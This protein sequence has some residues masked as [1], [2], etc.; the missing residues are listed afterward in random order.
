MLDVLQGFVHELR[1]AGLPVSMTENLDAMRAIEYVP[2]RRPH[3]VQ[4]RARRDAREERR[5]LPGVRHGLRGVLLDVLARRRRRRRA[6][7]EPRVAGQLRGAAR[8]HGP[9]RR[10]EPGVERGARADAPRRADADG[11][12]RDAHARGRGGRALRGDGAGPARRRRVLPLPHA[13]AARRRRSRLQDDGEGAR[14]SADRRGRVRRAARPGRLRGPA[15]GPEGDDRSGDPQ[16]ARR[17]SRGRGDGA[18]A[19]QAVARRRR[20]HARVSR[21][22]AD[23]AEGDLS[24]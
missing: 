1:T 3:R 24:A 7:H 21:R 17:G 11:P 20:L 23:A 8:R 22:D 19:A 6:R 10:H 2:A 9:G 14:G 12:E 15:E 16:A 4:G 5:S 18:H 13:A